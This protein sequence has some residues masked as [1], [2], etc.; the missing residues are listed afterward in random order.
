MNKKIHIEYLHETKDYALLK[1]V[2]YEI[3]IP[4]FPDPEDH[5][6]WSKVKNMIKKS[7]DNPQADDRILICISKEEDDEGKLIPISF[8]VSVYYKR[9]KTLLISYMGMRNGY[10]GMSLFAIQKLLLKEVEREAGK[11][12]DKLRAVFS[13]VDLPEYTQ[14]KYN[15]VPPIQR[16]MIM[17]RHGG[18]HIPIKFYYPTYEFKLLSMFNPKIEY[19]SDAGLLGYKLYDELITNHPDI[20]KEFIDDFYRFYGIEPKTDPKVI[21]MKEQIDNMPIGIN[22]KLSSKYRKKEK[23]QQLTS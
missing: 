7:F 13:L 10:N 12:S 8:I 5:L 20:I 4:C 11:S 2:Y 18:H 1:R 16:I 6:T 14:E 23:I 19:K 21:E 3:L 17:E 15:T 9:S 22:V